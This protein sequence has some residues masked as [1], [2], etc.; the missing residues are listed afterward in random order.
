MENNSSM[1]VD[2]KIDSIYDLNWT[3][4]GHEIFSTQISS[5]GEMVYLGTDGGSMTQLRVMTN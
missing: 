5:N 2:F 3:E 4:Y 1:N